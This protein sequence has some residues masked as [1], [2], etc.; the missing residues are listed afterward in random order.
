MSIS[1]EQFLKRIKTIKDN[2][3]ITALKYSVGRVDPFEQPEKFANMKKRYGDIVLR[4][5]LMK[6]FENYFSYTATQP[7]YQ[8]YPKDYVKETTKDLELRQKYLPKAIEL[9]K[10]FK[11]ADVTPKDVCM[12]ACRRSQYYHPGDHTEKEKNKVKNLE[13]C[14]TCNKMA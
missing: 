12:L 14:N 10:I 6:A 9:L 13:F 7:A 1:I 4:P 11:E 8:M 2:D 3:F 5:I